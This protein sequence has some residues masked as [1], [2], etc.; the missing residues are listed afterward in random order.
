MMKSLNVVV[1]TPSF[2]RSLPFADESILRRIREVSPDI[3][4]KDASP[5]MVAEF[6]GDNSKKEQMDKILADADVIFGLLLPGDI[7][8]RAPKLKWLQMM[9]A[10]VD[11]L[12]DTEIWKSKITITGVSGIHASPIGEFVMGFILMLAKGMPQCF[13]MKQN[14]EWQR[15][16]PH[17]LRGKTVG[18]V[19]LGHIGGEVARLSKA[20]GMKVIATR[21]S[22]KKPVKA[23]NVDLLLPQAQMNEMLAESDF[24]VLALPLTPETRHIIGAAEL[25]AMKQSAFIINIG[26]GNLIDEAALIRVLDEKGIAGAGL[27][28][29]ATEPLPKESRLWDME[30]VIVSPH[31]SGGM[32][33]YMDRAAA[34]FCENLKRFLEGKR[35]INVIDRKKGY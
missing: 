19:G 26:R 5:F 34:L 15:Y 18:I 6:Q 33:D 17:L 2:D 32:E 14:H 24:V 7:L 35:L 31:V 11:R 3:S 1:A 12:R 20:F 4:V 29:T 25:R 28:V 23:R 21:R 13:R 9:S 10:G 16:M 22:V 30:N 27:D 8:S